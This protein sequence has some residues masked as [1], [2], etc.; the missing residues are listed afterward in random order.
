MSQQNP[1]HAPASS[2]SPNVTLLFAHGGGFCRQIWDPI[3]RE[4]QASPLLQQQQS[5]IATEFVTFDFPLHGANRDES[6]TPKLLLENPTSPRV[7]HTGN[8]WM[9][10]GPAEV[11]AQVQALRRKEEEHKLP[12]AKLIG[13]GHSMGAASLWK[14]EVSH[15][16]TFDGLILFEPIYGVVNAVASASIDFLVSISLKRESRWPSREDAVRHFEGFRNFAAFDRESL[17]AYLDGALATAADGSTVLACH[18]H[19]EASLYCGTPLLLAEDELARAQCAIHLLGGSRS[20]LFARPYFDKMAAALPHIYAVSEP[21]PN[22]SHAMVL[23][24]PRASAA[25]V[26]AALKSLLV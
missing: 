2:S 9:E 18:P 4:L 7:E 3:I 23:E 6:V 8:A 21:M 16:G 13:V 15:P 10:W 11:L 1:E 5:G 20:R 19:I 12:R 17:A 22:A 26:L 14:I 24:Q 25:E